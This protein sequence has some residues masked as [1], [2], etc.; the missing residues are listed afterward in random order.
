MTATASGRDLVEYVLQAVQEVAGDPDYRILSPTEGA[1]FVAYDAHV[2]GHRWQVA[3]VFG[4][5]SDA[6]INDMRIYSR[7]W[8]VTA[9]FRGEIYKLLRGTL[10]PNYWQGESPLL[11]LG[12]QSTLSTS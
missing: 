12:E 1:L 3:A 9:F 7:P 11:S 8:P 4:L 2:H 10:G 6:E 5:N